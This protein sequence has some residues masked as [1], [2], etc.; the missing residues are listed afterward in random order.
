M[1]SLIGDRVGICS[2]NHYDY[3][4]TFWAC[5]ESICISQTGSTETAY[6]RPDRCSHCTCQCVRCD[7]CSLISGLILSFRWLPLK[8]LEHCLVY[9]GCKL[10]IV[11]PERAS[12]VELI[13]SRLKEEIGVTGFLVLD[14]YNRSWK[15]MESLNKLVD[16]HPRCDDLSDILSQS[17][18]PEDN[19]TIIFTSGT[20]F[21]V[22]FH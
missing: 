2:R 20:C 14:R 5:R 7:L 19:A 8:P 18:G 6:T 21:L 3:L 16:A 10:I 11:D 22:Y 1:T 12:I 9:T 13:T 4:V 17:I 15:H